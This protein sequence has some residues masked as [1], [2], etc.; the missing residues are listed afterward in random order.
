MFCGRFF[1]YTLQ[2][3]LGKTHRSREFEKRFLETDIGR[4]KYTIKVLHNIVTC[5]G[6][7]DE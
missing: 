5:P 3:A 1:T 2:H 7:R 4:R 6:F